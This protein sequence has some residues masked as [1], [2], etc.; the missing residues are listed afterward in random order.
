[1]R[2]FCRGRP[3]KDS[4]SPAQPEQPQRPFYLYITLE[5]AGKIRAFS[6][7]VSD[8]RK[9]RPCVLS[10]FSICYPNITRR[11]AGRGIPCYNKLARLMRQKDAAI[12][13]A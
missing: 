3:A 11:G 8:Y 9:S 4:F 7:S 1:M 6:D 13:P 10:H 5:R 12:F 2:S